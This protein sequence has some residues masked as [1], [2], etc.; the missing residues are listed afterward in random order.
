MLPPVPTHNVVMFF[1]KN[2]YARVRHAPNYTP[3]LITI[4]K[5][6][7]RER[8]SRV[9]CNPMRSIVNLTNA[10]CTLRAWLVL[11]RPL[12]TATALA[13]LT[14]RSMVAALCL[15]GCYTALLLSARLHAVVAHKT[16]WATNDTS[17]SRF[18]SS[19]ITAPRVW[20]YVSASVRAHQSSPP[21]VRRQSSAMMPKASNTDVPGETLGGILVVARCST[22][23]HSIID[24]QK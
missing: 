11:S 4:W 17:V 14:R 5:V 1:V 15:N 6:W 3:T 13:R 7:Q 18:R 8:E 21:V 16:L 9:I 10:R 24:L 22:D 2:N 20:C 12:S 19:N 23:L